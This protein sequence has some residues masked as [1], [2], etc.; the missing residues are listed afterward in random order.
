MAPIG[1][2]P[3][4]TFTSSSPKQGSTEPLSQPMLLLVE[5]RSETENGEPS[6]GRAGER[7]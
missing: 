1:N 3:P 5:N 6:E 4:A 2:D 7:R